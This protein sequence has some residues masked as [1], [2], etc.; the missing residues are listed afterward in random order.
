MPVPSCET[1]VAMGKQI[2]GQELTEKNCNKIIEQWI[3]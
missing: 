3:K 1:I 2:M